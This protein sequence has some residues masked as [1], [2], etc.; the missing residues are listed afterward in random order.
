MVQN[1]SK[2][3]TPFI[4]WAGGKRK[5]LPLLHGASPKN[6]TRVIE[7]F[8]GGGAFFFSTPSTVDC[9][10]ND[11]NSELTTTYK[12]VRDDLE[13]LLTSLK[14]LSK[15]T[16]KEE[17]LR[18]RALQPSSLTDVERASRVIYLNKTC[19][20]GLW[21]E[22]SKG[23]F[24]V[25]WGNRPDAVIYNESVLRNASARLQNVEILNEPVASLFN[26]LVSEMKI[27]NSSGE[28]FLQPGTLIYL[29]PPYIPLTETA[30]FSQYS[31]NGFNG[32]DQLSLALSISELQSFGVDVM[33][34]NSDTVL[35]REIF[36]NLNLVSIKASRSIAAS[37]TSRQA[38]GEVLG[39]SYPESK[40]VNSAV[41]PVQVI[42]AKIIESEKN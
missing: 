2:T 35:S 19:F 17:F 29:D 6:Y 38:V 7:P 25:P 23:V 26:R 27:K 18:I 32:D 10:I 30:S 37:G 40:C 16:S 34:S 36:K 31:K 1:V 22:N 13:N 9:I 33:L 14:T 39:L 4:K 20:N 3:P 12:I 21:R 8:V 28:K 24:N 11:V 41:L 42:P 5:L 15:D